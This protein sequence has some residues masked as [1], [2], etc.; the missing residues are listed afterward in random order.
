MVD[1]KVVL[2]K[3]RNIEDDMTKETRILLITVSVNLLIA[4]ILFYS[5][6]A[7]SLADVFDFINDFALNFS[8]G[9]AGL[10]VSAYCC[11]ILLNK[12]SKI[13]IYHGVLAIFAVLFVGTLAGSTVGFIQEGLPLSKQYNEPLVEAVND[14]YFKPFFWIFFFGLIPTLISGIIVGGL[15]RRKASRI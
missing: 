9:I 6:L 1:K 5:I 12:K 2:Q 11:G 13:R 14:Y 4:F 3:K 7:S 10:Y 8:V 15:L